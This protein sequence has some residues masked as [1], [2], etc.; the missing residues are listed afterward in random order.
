MKKKIT[1]T[2]FIEELSDEYEFQ[3]A[4]NGMTMK[5]GIDLALDKIRSRLKYCDD[6]SDAETAVLEDIR[7]ILSDATSGIDE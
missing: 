6:V 2:Y 3:C 1:V 4:Q 7:S 5:L